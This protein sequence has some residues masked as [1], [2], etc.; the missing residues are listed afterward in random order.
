[1]ALCVAE[2]AEMWTQLRRLLFEEGFTKLR[3]G[4]ELGDDGNRDATAC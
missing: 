4:V 3:A 2:T 1:M